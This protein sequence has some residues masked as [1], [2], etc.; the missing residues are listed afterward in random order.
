MFF[1]L[2]FFGNYI[3]LINEKIIKSF[4]V[5]MQEFISKLIGNDLIATIV[6]SLIPMIELK[7]GIV[8][9][10]ASMGFFQALALAYVGSTLVFIPIY[11]LLRPILNLLKKIKWFNS[12]AC[13]VENYFKDKADQTLE[14]QA[15]KK[16]GGRI[17]EKLLKQ[18]GV[19]IFIAI[20]LPL[21]GVWTGTA[22]AVFLNLKFKDEILPVLLGNLVAGLIIS[23]LA[24]L[25]IAVWTIQSLE[26]ILWGLFALAVILLAITIIKVAKQKPKEKE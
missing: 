26:Y 9:A 12:L 13:K 3:I 6:M 4:G 18:L 15:E 22:I 1:K 5:K 7:G 2:I 23:L 10:R 25:C 24:E 20:P 17:S 21:T 11:F 8:F 19:F 14:K 16:S